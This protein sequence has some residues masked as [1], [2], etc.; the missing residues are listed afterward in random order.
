MAAG[1]PGCGREMPCSHWLAH[2][3]R[4]HHRLRFHGAGSGGGWAFLYWQSGS[5]DL[6]AVEGAR[7]A[8]AELRAVDAGWNQQLV[9]A[10]LYA[11]DATPASAAPAAPPSHRHRLAYASLE[12]RG[13]RLGSSLVG[14]ELAQ[15][16]R[17]FEEKSA[18]IVR[19]AEA[20]AA[21]ATAQRGVPADDA[22][23]AELRAIADVLFDQAWLASTG[24]RLDTLGRAIDR[25]FDEVLTQAE[26]YRIGLLYYSGFL[27]AVLVFLTWNLDQ[28]RRQIDRINHELRD[29]NETLEARVAER[30]R[31]LSDALARLKESEAML[32]QSEKMSSLGQM[33]A[34]IAH[35]VNTPLAYVKSSLEAVGK[36]VPRVGRLAAQTERLLALLS[37]EGADEAALA[38]QFALVRGLVEEL[39][40]KTA[41]HTA[42]EEL[43]RL[44]KDGL[45]GIG[46][47]SDVIA[48]LKNFSRLD[49]SMVADYDLHE[50]IESAIR[51]GYAQLQNRIVHREFGAIPHVSCAPSQINQVVLNL[52]SNAAQATPEGTGTITVRTR[53]SG[54]A[55][56]AL[57]VADNGTGIPVDVL[58]KIFDPFFTTKALGKGTG[59]GLAICHKIAENHGGKLEVQSSLGKGTRFVLVLPIK[60]AA[61]AA[62]PS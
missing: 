24:P 17:A 44:I 8:L 20:Q 15:V 43:E 50:G 29:A 55:H 25:V 32:I 13:M 10:R 23:L 46:Q 22:K 60:A 45:F 19:F 48:N 5:V 1:P 3:H 12:V 6:A 52:L 34:G 27:L 11:R 58:P 41:G 51:I 56:V 37:V 61:L 39:G 28:R 33:V 59:L 26:L 57:E 35:E 42:L 16:K 53:M 31:E 14:S 47:I 54:N 36:G 7:A 2:A 62:R 18:L 21:L 9:N 40:T 4:P 30:T 38:A 49:R